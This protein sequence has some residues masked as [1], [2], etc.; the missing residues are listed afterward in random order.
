MSPFSHLHTSLLT[1]PLCSSPTLHTST[2]CHVLLHT[3]TTPTFPL[4]LQVLKKWIGQMV[5]ALHY[6][7]QK[8]MIHRRVLYLPSSHMSICRSCTLS[9]HP[10]VHAL[11]DVS[12]LHL[13]LNSTLVTLSLRYRD[14]K[15]SNIFLRDDSSIAVGMHHFSC[16]HSLPTLLKSMSSTPSLPSSL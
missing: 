12:Q 14:L 5:E 9:P 6:V 11:N 8:Q 1:L 4:L 2:P 16:T 15:P 3:L 13:G 10:Y 7:H